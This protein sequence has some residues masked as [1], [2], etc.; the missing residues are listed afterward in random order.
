MALPINIDKL[1]S[2]EVVESTRIEFKGGFNPNPIMHSICAFA[3]DIDNIGGGYII[4]GVD[5]DNGR[6]VLPPRGI[7]QSEVDRTLKRY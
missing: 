7:D 3:N 6:P 1:V 2:G 4:I 5:E